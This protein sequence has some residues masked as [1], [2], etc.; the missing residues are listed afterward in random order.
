MIDTLIVIVILASPVD[1]VKQQPRM[2]DFARLEQASREA[3]RQAWEETKAEREK[4][5]NFDGIR[6][7]V[8]EL[9]RNSVKTKTKNG[10]KR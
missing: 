9:E 6:A 1:T 5:L 7:I 8:E 10:N 3:A 2:F 4:I